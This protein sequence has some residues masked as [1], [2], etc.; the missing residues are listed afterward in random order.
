M[1]DDACEP[2]YEGG[3]TLIELLIVI[4]IIGVLA[5]IAIPQY[6]RYLE[7]AKAE[8]V[9]GN[10]KLAVDAV[11]LAY[12]AANNQVTTNVYNTLNGD[13]VHN[14]ANPVYG[15]GSAGYM[16]LSPTNSQLAPVCGQV[17]MSASVVS[18]AGPRFITLLVGTNCN[19]PGMT[20]AISNA[21]SAAGFAHATSRG[22]SVY[23]DGDITP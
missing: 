10:L 17:A 21:C 4:A 15:P 12:A 14:V 8:V 19:S 1:R 23:Q 5:A 16:V 2:W 9:V 22:V 13:V 7:D 18:V 11:S 20:A 6:F 3:L